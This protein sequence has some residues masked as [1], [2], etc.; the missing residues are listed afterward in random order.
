MLEGK[1]IGGEFRINKILHG[2]TENKKPLYITMSEL[3]NTGVTIEVT[4]L[5][6]ID[7][8]DKDLIRL[9]NVKI[10]VKVT[11]EF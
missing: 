5:R 2:A 6:V 11:I 4:G 1:T 3:G 9:M 8:F 10:P 7:S